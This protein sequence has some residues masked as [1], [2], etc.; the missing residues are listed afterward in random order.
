MTEVYQVHQKE[1]ARGG[2]GRRGSRK[3]SA[4][5]RAIPLITR[6][7]WQRAASGLGRA[8]PLCVSL[9]P[10]EDQ[11]LE[12]G[13]PQACVQLYSSAFLYTDTFMNELSL[14]LKKGFLST[15]IM[16]NSVPFSAEVLWQLMGKRQAGVC[17]C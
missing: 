7:G 16:G 4:L 10:R 1:G 8:T 13:A 2:G 12:S 3:R 6:R 5:E 17:T 9:P 14:F 11:G 15:G